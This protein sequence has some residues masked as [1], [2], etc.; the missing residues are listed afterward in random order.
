M[1]APD[2]VHFFDADRGKKWQIPVLWMDEMLLGVDKPPG[3]PVIPDRWHPEWPCLHS[4]LEKRLGERPFVVHRLD[5]GTSGVMVMARTSVAH[6]HLCE[7]F[8]HHQVEKTYH[9]V[10]RGEWAMQEQVIDLALAP[11]PRRPGE[12]MVVK[13]G[14][15]CRTEIR[16]LER[17][18]GITSVEAR[19]RSG[20]Q[21][22]IRVHLQAAGHPL[23][24]DP[25]YGDREA[26]Y[27]SSLKP[28]MRF[29]KDEEERP[30]IS[31]LSLHASSL[32]FVHP[33]SGAPQ[34]I[35]AEPPKDFK[36]L[37]KALRKYARGETME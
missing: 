16:R 36:A 2:I 31:R 17:F 35:T 12:M 28:R 30:L 4:I 3:L 32:Q 33:V 37:L 25:V 26:F 34:A 9:A 18:R 15:P 21:H 13:S 27:L 1:S 23:L 11:N 19:P 6:H 29:A 5:A 7:Q 22:Q 20:R 10:V 8:S 14:K 24:V